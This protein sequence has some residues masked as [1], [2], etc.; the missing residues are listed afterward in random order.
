M[1]E[2]SAAPGDLEDVRTF[3]NSWLIPNDTRVTVDR[4]PGLA[5]DSDDWAAAMP[6]IPTPTDFGS[7]TTGPGVPPGRLADLQRLRDDF[8]AALGSS[9]P[10]GLQPLFEQL[11]LRA[12]VTEPGGVGPAVRLVPDRPTTENWILAVVVEA[13]RA[14]HWARLRACPDCQWVFYD[15]SRNAR[16]QWCAMVA[17]PTAR[18]CGSIAKTR[19]YRARQKRPST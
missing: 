18:G 6:S 1:D 17:G 19:S 9:H 16:R 11:E 12:E 3:L 13:V 5:G 2:R 4:L 10:T 15:S 8:R 7:S 14:G